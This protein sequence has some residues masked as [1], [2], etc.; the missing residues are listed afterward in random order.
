MFPHHELHVSCRWEDLG[1]DSVVVI[2]QGVDVPGRNG[3]FAPAAWGPGGPGQDPEVRSGSGPGHVEQLCG[4][5]QR[6]SSYVRPHPQ[7]GSQQELSTSG[8]HPSPVEEEAAPPPCTTLRRRPGWVEEK[9]P[10]KLLLNCLKLQQTAGGLNVFIISDICRIRSE[11][12]VLHL[13]T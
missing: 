12:P 3:S 7:G 10:Y 13:H 9:E 5:L 6:S 8:A 4:A 11:L 1:P 2:Q